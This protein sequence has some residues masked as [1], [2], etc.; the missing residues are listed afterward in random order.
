MTDVAYVNILENGV[1]HAVYHL[2]GT[3]T[4]TSN[5]SGVKK[6]DVANDFTS[7]VTGYLGKPTA[8]ALEYIKS[9]CQGGLTA[10]LL[11]D[12]TTPIPFWTIPNTFQEVDLRDSAWITNTAG[13]GKTGNILL[14]T[15][16]AAA[17]GSYDIVMRLRKT[18]GN[19]S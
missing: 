6:V 8:V 9:V 16:G 3:F 1:K 10:T 4:D 14:T 19:A 15:A 11:W 7:V 18:Y 13:A 2:T 12:A 17:G 5:E